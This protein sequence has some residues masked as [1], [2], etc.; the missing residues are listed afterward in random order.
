MTHNPILSEAA[1]SAAVRIAGNIPEASHPL[2]RDALVTAYVGAS[3]EGALARHMRDVSA[4]VSGGFQA[5][6]KSV[7]SALQQLAPGKSKRRIAGAVMAGNLHAR[8]ELKGAPA[9]LHAPRRAARLLRGLAAPRTLPTM[10][11]TAMVAAPTGTLSADRLEAIWLRAE[12]GCAPMGRPYIGAGYDSDGNVDPVF[13]AFAFGPM[14]AT[15]Q[16]DFKAREVLKGIEAFIRH[17]HAQAAKGLGPL[18]IRELVGEMR[19]QGQE[20]TLLSDSTTIAG[21]AWREVLMDMKRQSFSMQALVSFLD[22][23]QFGAR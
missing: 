9:C 12:P 5:S 15:G 19:A 17:C 1:A 6:S 11:T 7:Q 14:L 16:Q 3:A 23:R 10:D 2:V 13:F 22:G 21:A 8:S 18:R 4:P 20:N